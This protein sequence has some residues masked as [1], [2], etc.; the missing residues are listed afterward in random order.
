MTTRQIF[1]GCISALL[2]ISWQDTGQEALPKQEALEFSL[3]SPNLVPIASSVEELAARI[4]PG[5]GQVGILDIQDFDLAGQAGDLVAHMAHR[6]DEMVNRLLLVKNRT[7]IDFEAG[8]VLE[9]SREATQKMPT[10]GG[11]DVHISCQGAACCYPS[12]TIGS[13]GTL[14]T[15]STGEAGPNNQCVMRIRDTPPD[16]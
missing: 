12:G 16:P 10:Q 2:L 7:T 6:A 5:Y 15:G 1:R 14:V 4:A 11:G 3:I 8:T 9:F 13:D